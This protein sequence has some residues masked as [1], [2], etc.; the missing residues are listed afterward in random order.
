MLKEYIKRFAICI[1]GLILFSVGN[2]FGV[3]AGSAG[4]NAWNT[5]ALG[6][7]GK[8][9][10][11]FGNATLVISMVIVLIAIICKGRIGFGTILNILL[12]AWFSDIILGFNLL[13]TAP[14][15]VF[16]VLYTLFGQ[17]LISFGM[18][19]YM[20]PGLGCGPRDTLMVIVG[21]RFPKAPIGLIKFCIE[22]AALAVGVLL[23]APFG[24]GTVLV[25]ALQATIF[26]LVCRLC[27][28]EP[29]SVVHEDI[30]QT[31]KRVSGKA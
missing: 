26:Q 27:R 17:T 6:M 10:L 29:R 3:Q 11:S 30:F 2:S 19:L 28:F 16:G 12:I 1:S 15:Q 31:I 25:M 8:T 23:G 21:N 18:I 5:L 24:I 20:S 9:P 4:T 7:S 22:L 14:N 13:P